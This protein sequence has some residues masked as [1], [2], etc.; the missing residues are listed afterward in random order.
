[1]TN[2]F[3]T[4]YHSNNGRSPMTQSL[5][6]EAL[7]FKN[8]RQMPLSQSNSP[9]LVK[10]EWS[11]LTKELVDTLPRVWTRGML[12]FLIVFAAILL[13][14]ATLSKVDETGSA[15]GRLEPKGKTFRLDAPVPGTVKKV[16][17]KEGQLVRE[18]Q[19]L[20]ALESEEVRNE[21]QQ[22]QI[23]LESQKNRLAQLE[24]L[25]NQLFLALRVQQQQNQAQELAKLSQVDQARQ[26]LD[27]SKTAY[28]LRKVEQF[29]QFNQA[30][31]NLDTSKASYELADNRYVKAIKEV[32]RY[33]QLWQQGVVP[34]VKVVEMKNLAEE[35][36]KLRLQTQSE[37]KQG[38][39]RLQEQQNQR[40]S[41]VHQAQSDIQ[42][43]KLRL[44]EQ[45]RS[46]QS[47]VKSDKLAMLKSE[48]QLK[49][50]ESQ[51]TSLTAENAQ[52]ISQITSL[53][54][55]LGQ[56]VLRAPVNGTLF[57][58]SIQHP[59]AVVQASQMVAEI[60]P[61]GESFLLRAQMATQQSG[62]IHEGMAVKV[63]FDAYPFQDYGVIEGRL[64]RISKT[65]NVTETA[66]GQVANFDLDVELKQSCIQSPKG[67][68]ALT[69]GQTA[70]AEVI[71]R[72]RRIIDFILDPFKKLQKGGL[73]L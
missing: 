72:Q 69:P 4:E 17:V 50:V 29:T 33:H 16:F 41:V 57:K 36:Q 64:I 70:T 58:L 46:Y 54:F 26:N 45:L 61:Q 53:K 2:S 49:D 24:L 60:A 31:Q 8:P 11:S 9:E 32:E 67:C 44:D 27:A 21:I 62:S 37:L 6:E 28:N 59:G 42:Q 12:Y 30:Q 7:D 47:I 23:K 10:N 68:I 66:Q 3:N 65:S 34:E 19:P 14:W 73:E 1:M 71:I 52:T 38:K 40:K 48:E 5:S 39:L 43:G 15:R 22:Q 35:N 56:R 51:I 55:Q 20:I 25:K 18:K 13:P 63:K